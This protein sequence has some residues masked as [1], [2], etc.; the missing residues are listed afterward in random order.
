MTLKFLKR[1]EK[2]VAEGKILLVIN[3]FQKNPY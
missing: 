2:L 1:L 3:P